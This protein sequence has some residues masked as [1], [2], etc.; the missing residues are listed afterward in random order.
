MTMAK[1]I[2]GSDEPIMANEPE[3]AYQIRR[4]EHPAH[5]Q[6]T[7]EECSSCVTL[8]ELKGELLDM[9]HNFYHPKS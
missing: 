7:T 8:D 1:D 4:E 5:R 2:T 3:I 9:V 6:M